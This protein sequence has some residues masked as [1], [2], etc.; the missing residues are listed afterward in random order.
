[1]TPRIELPSSPR[2][3]L[4]I[5]PSALGDIVHTL[6]ILKRLRQRWPEAHIAWLVGSAFAN[7][8][9]GHPLLNE[10]LAF[11]RKRYS[12][13][14]RN[15]AAL[16]ALMR[17]LRGLSDRNDELVIDLQGLL[18]SGWLSGATEAP[19][20]VGFANARELAHLF[21]TH[22]VPIESMQQ[23]AVDRYL[24]IAEALGCGRGPVE[25]EFHVEPDDQRH[26][27]AQVE[28]LGA[29][30]VLLPGTNW[31]TKRWPVEHFAALVRPLRE[32]FGL[33]C[34]VAGGPDA[35][36]LAAQ[37][38]GAA[39]LTGQTTLRQL[40]A[41]LRRAALVIANDSGPMHIAAALNRPLVTI[42]GPTNPLRTGPYGR[43]DSVVRLDIPCSPCYSRKCSHISCMK[44]LNIEPVLETAGK[45]MESKNEG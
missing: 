10:T 32:R 14:W 38:P 27:A 9:D 44:W 13:S 29:Y 30:A 34:V 6:P 35:V 26:V 19:V 12:R 20:R 7:L 8:I 36:P 22:H 39:N 25:F 15:P 33:S 45:Q 28:T 31:I 5:K 24:A 37:I 18:R 3:I 21:Y 43:D 40:V 11:D 42:F 41:L 16:V 23:H 1:M 2:R 4:I 17:F